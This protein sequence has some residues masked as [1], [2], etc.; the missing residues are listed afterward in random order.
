MYIWITTGGSHG[1][2]HP[3]LAIGQALRRRGHEVTLSAHPYFRAD[4]E[5]AGIEHFAMNPE[6]ELERILNDPQFM[7][8]RVGGRRVLDMIF[9]CVPD[10]LAALR[11]AMC[12]RRPDVVLSHHICIGTRWLCDE[13]RLPFVQSQLAPLTWLSGSDPVPP[14]QR[15]P[16]ALRRAGARFL[17][18]TFLPLAAA[19]F[20]RRINRLRRDVGYPPEKS[21][22]LA[23]WFGGDAN[24]GLWSP[25]FRGPTDR[26]PP[27]ARLCG[28]C[29]YD[30]SDRTPTLP[31]ELERFLDAG[32]PPVV[33][34]LGT[35]AVHN[36]GDFYHV[37]ADACARLGRRGVLLVGKDANVP[38]GLGASLIA[39][40]YVPFSLLFPRAGVIVHHG[41]IGSTAQ[42]LR[43]GRPTVVVPH[44]HD[45]FHNALHAHRLGVAHCVPRAA[46]S[47]ARLADALVRMADPAVESAA[48]ALRAHVR[49]EDGTSVACD[50]L[51]RC[52][53]DDYPRRPTFPR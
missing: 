27:R 23:D 37:A 22:F 14:M 25:H 12:A 21:A 39:L 50:E 1:D 46:L 18:R 40:H 28:F 43:A 17:F 35:A 32:D 7:H 19:W 10:A 53:R 52:A 30:R 11:G 47:V 41:G 48:A 44:A 5:A 24:L 26:D 49:H 2:L 38:A 36:P 20:G 9:A 8:P 51:E 16:G 45:Q 15:R 29:C 3:F 6:I 4:V 13:L 42:A 33:F 34:A 31:I